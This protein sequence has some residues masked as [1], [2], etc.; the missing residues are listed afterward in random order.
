LLG[1]N[2]F[3]PQEPHGGHLGQLLD[4][5]QGGVAQLRRARLAG[6]EAAIAVDEQ[7]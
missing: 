6:Q 3:Q 5:R 7:P 2:E 4:L 1:A